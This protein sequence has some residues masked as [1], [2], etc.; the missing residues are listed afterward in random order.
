MAESVA[1]RGE[2]NSEAKERKQKPNFSVY[3]I[4]VIT[5]NVK[6][7]LDTIQSKL[8]KNVTNKKKQEIWE[9]ITR[10][11]NAVRTTNRTV[12]EAKDKWKNLHSTAK[13]AFSEFKRELK[14]TGGGPP[15][16]PPSVSSKEIIDVFEDTP[17]FS[18][19]KGFET[20]MQTN[21][22]S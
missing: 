3:K 11:V 7:H 2:V 20:G 21:G 5:E 8:T 18:G 9:D 6:K 15:P 16:K 4:G 1:E 22:C 13:K 14:K 19:L 12:S 17:G 10:A